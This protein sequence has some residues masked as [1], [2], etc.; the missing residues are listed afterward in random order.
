MRQEIIPPRERAALTVIAQTTNNFVRRV[1]MLEDEIT[2]LAPR[3]IAKLSELIDDPNPAIALSA[4][5]DVLDR[6]LGKATIRVK[7]HVEVQSLHNQHHAAL[8]GLA[9]A[10]QINTPEIYTEYAEY[11]EYAEYT[12]TLAREENE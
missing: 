1:A 4:A 8:M 12:E 9:E 5:K 6:T 11:A 10:V 2:L 3:A 7:Q